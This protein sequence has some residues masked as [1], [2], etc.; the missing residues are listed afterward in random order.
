MKDVPPHS[1]LCLLIEIGKNVKA[2]RDI[3]LSDTHLIEASDHLSSLVD[4]NRFH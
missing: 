3:Y 1:N 2:G 4:L